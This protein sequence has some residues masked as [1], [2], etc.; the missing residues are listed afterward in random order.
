[1][2]KNVTWTLATVFLTLCIAA[3][4]NGLASPAPTVAVDP[5]EVK[6][7]QQGESFTVNLTISD[8]VISEDPISNGLYGWSVK[9]TF[10]PAI[11]NVAT[12][13]EGPFLQQAAETVPLPLRMNNTAGYAFVGAMINI[14]WGP[15]GATGSGVL[16][17]ITF[18][19]MGRGST[20][21]E[22]ESLELYTAHL[23]PVTE[24]WKITKFTAIDG[25]FV[26]AAAF[27]IELIVGVIGAAA[28]GGTLVVFF[29]R[30]RK[31]PTK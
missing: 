4:T 1:M 18:T 16:A 13:T 14:P 5:P 29:Y 3:I 20:K 7:L 21:L 2:K 19:V 9:V 6:D 12:V 10:N 27:P 26:N 17:T 30:R 8:I 31:T 15:Q 24:S 25:Q 23:T 11:L 22:L 28:I